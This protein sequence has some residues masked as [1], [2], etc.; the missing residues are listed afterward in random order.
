MTSRPKFRLIIAGRDNGRA[1]AH[2]AQGGGGF[3]AEFPSFGC[4]QVGNFMSF[5]LA[6]HIFDRIEFRRVSGQAFQDQAPAGGGDVILDE[7]TAMD[8]RAIP[9]NHDFAGDVPSQ[10]PEKLDD[11]GAFDAA[12]M[13][14]KVKP[15]Q[16]QPANN[17]K[18][19]P[20]EG[21]VQH[22]S[23]PARSPGANP[24]RTGAQPAFIDKYD[25]S[26]LP[27]GLFFKAGHS[28]RC[29]R[30]MAFSSRSTARRSGRWQLKPLAPINRQT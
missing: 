12:L 15:P 22:W 23:L 25:G 6:P 2:A 20:V 18:A 30:R 24:R 1:A 8:R 11:L 4:Q 9:K 14:L 10:V 5:E 7:Q 21:F 26:S 27:A 29:Q 3:K 16:R 13:D 28:T 19:F 17:R